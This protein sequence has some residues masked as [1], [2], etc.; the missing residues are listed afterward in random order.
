MPNLPL[1]CSCG[2]MFVV[3]AAQVGK[4]GRAQCP[5]CLRPVLLDGPSTAA[6]PRKK[7]RVLATAPDAA[8]M[9]MMVIVMG[10][11]ALVV[12]AAIVLLL[13]STGGS[14]SPRDSG[15]SSLY[16]PAASPRRYQPRLPEPPPPPP[17]DT[18]SGRDPLNA[19]GSA[20]RPA[21][22]APGAPSPG[23]GSAGAFN[24]VGSAIQAGPAAAPPAALAPD[25]LQ[26][27][28]DE[29]LGLHPFYQGLAL[30][31]EEKA[32]VEALARA[33]T[34]TPNDEAFLRGILVGKV[35]AARDERAA[36]LG[37]LSKL[38]GEAFEG[39]PVDRLVLGDGRIMTGKVVEETPEQ[40]KIER[41]MAGGVGGV[42]NFK[43]EALRS[44][45]KGKGPGGE[46]K[47]RWESARKGTTAQ[48]ASLAAWCREN[49]LTL[50]QELVNYQILAA[51]PGNLA[52]RAEAG[53]AADPVARALEAD[54]QGGFI[55]HQGR[56][57]I[58]QELKEKLLRDGNFLREG[59]WY[60]R[61]ER[62]ITVPGLFKYER[63]SDKP[64]LISGNAPL[65]HD[66]IVTYVTVQDVTTNSFIEREDVKL[67]RAFYAPTLET[68]LS[69]D[70]F[71]R[72]PLPSGNAELDVQGRMDVG[73]PVAGTPVSGEVFITVPLGEP[74]IEASV[75][76]HAEVKPGGS[77]GVFLIHDAQRIHLYN[78]GSKEDT[79][80]KLPDLV[81]GK[82]QVDLVAVI[83][84]KAAY[85]LKIEKRRARGLK[86]DARGFVIQKALD[87][88]H[89]R[90]IPDF[91]AVLF[92]SNS[93]TIEVFRLRVTTGEAAH[94]LN[95]LFER[96]PAELLKT[97]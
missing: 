10:G 38:E 50:Q 39:L 81:K 73:A 86:R 37:A 64:V 9:K 26:A 34:G 54:K 76:T 11:G 15:T 46:F 85:T 70:A 20:V 44:L 17:P 83:S 19:V 57:W 42:M 93:N 16:D 95:K 53:L 71:V 13:V 80:R 2:Y 25:L 30:T 77:I 90:L 75:T 8:R 94:G 60:Q 7:V 68:R 49:G 45:E 47:T 12:V 36:I 67:A 69:S 58:P 87:I 40:V 21:S 3:D 27:V 24:P 91:Q 51:D 52:A 96:A 66:K 62:M 61:K 55:Q 5:S 84:A 29:A 41:R 56:A 89:H 72:F 6:P 48:L 32:R 18:G 31:K 22:P 35:K 23:A 97:P 28:R 65:N 43:R 82:T 59:Q 79:S 78:C 33:G 92:P 63:Q 88:V 4:A 14:S 1:R 74:I